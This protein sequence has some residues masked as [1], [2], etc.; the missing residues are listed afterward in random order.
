MDRTILLNGIEYTRKD[1]TECCPDTCCP[2]KECCKE[3]PDWEARECAQLNEMDKAGLESY[4][5]TGT[6]LSFGVPMKYVEADVVYTDEDEKQYDFID[7]AFCSPN[8]KYNVVEGRV[9]AR[10]RA[11]RMYKANCCV[12]KK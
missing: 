2:T 4:I 3:A 9:R 11:L 1:K 10:G 7:F 6:T 12:P 8:D 5:Y